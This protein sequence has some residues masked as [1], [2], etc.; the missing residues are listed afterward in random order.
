MSE[1]DG[2]G[3]AA[4]S[5]LSAR[6]TPSW[7]NDP[8]TTT[9]LFA[10]ALEGGYDDEPPWDAV[11]TLRLRGTPEVFEIAARYCQSDNP[12]ARARGL[13]VLAQLGAGKPDSERPYLDEGVSTAINHLKDEDPLVVRSAAYALAHLR[14][15]TAVAALIE[16]RREPDPGVRHAVAYGMGGVGQ[17]EAVAALVELMEDVDDDVRDWAT[18]ALG[19][20]CNEDSPEIREALRK[21]IDD[22]FEDARQEAIWGLAR[23]KDNLGLRLL[24]QRLQSPSWDPGDEDAA[25]ETLGVERATPVEALCDGLRRLLEGST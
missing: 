4:S 23:R 11:A 17:P 15:E 13:D 1:S 3:K 10:A 21:R 9:D 22:P 18:F 16:I 6:A 25:V 24:F 5:E 14:T 12:K 20:L 7:A 8:R 2:K 19:S